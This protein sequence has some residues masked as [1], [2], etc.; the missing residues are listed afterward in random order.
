MD[1]ILSSADIVRREV[2]RATVRLGL[3][4]RLVSDRH[5]RLAV[6]AAIHM[7]VALTLT[8]VAPVWL[9]LFAPL[10]LGVPHIFADVRYL[11]LRP[12]TR[13]E[14]IAMLGVILPLV[15]MTIFRVL[16][17]RGCPL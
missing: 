11:I 15:G 6:L 12:P 17:E 13:V 16:Q 3:A 7:A 5:A 9:L 10:L 8:V 4:P 2:W 1:L 14:R